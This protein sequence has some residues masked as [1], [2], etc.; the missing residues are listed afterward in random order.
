MRHLLV[1]LS[2]EIFADVPDTSKLWKRQSMPSIAEI[3][4]TDED[5]GPFAALLVD[6]QP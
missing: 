2:R 6:R 4:T 1:K 5:L 3:T